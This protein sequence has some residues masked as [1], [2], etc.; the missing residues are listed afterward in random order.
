MGSQLAS[1]GTAETAPATATER[2]R[3]HRQRRREGL[4]CVTVELRE[5]EIQALIT[6]GL[7]A[8]ETRN[9][10][11][12]IIEALYAFLDRTLVSPL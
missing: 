11:N 9:D 1:G 2:M 10:T 7:L 8:P 3:R 6:R 5:T 12:A 4:R